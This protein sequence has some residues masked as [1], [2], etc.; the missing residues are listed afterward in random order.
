M[1]GS[2]GSPIDSV[3]NWQQVTHSHQVISSRGEGEGPT[4]SGD[5]TMTSLAQA[6][7]RLE[8]AEDLFH[9]FALLLAEQVAGV[10]SAASVDRRTRLIVGGD[11]L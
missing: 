4:T 3:G 1:A 11:G 6:G 2:G 9:S 5:C 8:P 10:A 7:D